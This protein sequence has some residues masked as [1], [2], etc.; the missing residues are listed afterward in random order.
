MS[1]AEKTPDTVPQSPEDVETARIAHR[2]VENAGEAIVEA[3]DGLE[4]AESIGSS[5]YSGGEKDGKVV[6]R[7][8]HEEV[9]FTPARK[10]VDVTK[11]PSLL[12]RV[13]GRAKI[14]EVPT[15]VDRHT[16]TEYEDGAVWHTT[17][18]PSVL[19]GRVEKTAYT[20]VGEDGT[21]DVSYEVTRYDED[22]KEVRRS[23]RDGKSD[24]YSRRRGSAPAANPRRNSAI[25]RTA[26]RISQ[27]VQRAVRGTGEDIG[28]QPGTD[29]EG[30]S[31]SQVPKGI[32][33]IVDPKAYQEKRKAEAQARKDRGE[34]P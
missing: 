20:T 33:K 8:D 17:V 13:F 10:T 19:G 15:E 29:A 32:E 4:P 31:V 6:E 24:L 1:V 25:L 12:K 11:K 7:G 34:W 26:G 21:S 2:I 28:M 18:R 23:R 27:R 5:V 3:S 30:R 9:G 22:G 14:D 16:I